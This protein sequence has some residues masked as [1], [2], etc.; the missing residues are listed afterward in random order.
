[1]A[2]LEEAA[3][4]RPDDPAPLLAIKAIHEAAEEWDKV[5]AVMR[6][7]M[8]NAG[9]EERYAL[10]VEAGDVLEFRFNV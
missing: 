6:R 8:E 5:V 1:M 4:L 10:L 7:R 9:D 3:Q 2:L